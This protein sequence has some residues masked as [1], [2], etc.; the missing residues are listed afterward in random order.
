M[1][2]KREAG[3]REGTKGRMVSSLVPP[4][5]LLSTPSLSP[6]CSE[7]YL[8]DG[9]GY[10]ESAQCF[11]VVEGERARAGRFEKENMPS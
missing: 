1:G 4:L 6:S 9:I 7:R 5:L 3:G 2:E 8:L 10:E 11:V